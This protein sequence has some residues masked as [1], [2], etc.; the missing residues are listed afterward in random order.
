MAQP[1]VGY[2]KFLYGRGLYGQLQITTGAIV[3]SAS[4]SSTII[5]KVTRIGGIAAPSSWV[6]SSTAAAH[7]IEAGRV[8]HSATIA[9]TRGGYLHA[10]GRYT[11]DAVLADSI[12]GL[13]KTIGQYVGGAVETSR[14]IA[15]LHADAIY[16]ANAMLTSAADGRKLWEDDAPDPD[17]GWAPQ[18]KPTSIWNP[19][20][21]GASPWTRVHR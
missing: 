15:S 4:A 3:S 17:P 19:V 2:G 18:P 7:P 16:V 13:R 5:G 20:P 10:A 21:E 12:V 8:V 11:A 14:I 6:E 1:T 9:S